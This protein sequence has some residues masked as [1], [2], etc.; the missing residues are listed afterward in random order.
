MLEKKYLGKHLYELRKSN[1]LTQ[2]ELGDIL[3]LTKQ[4]IGKIEKGER[5]A[6]IEVINAIADYF[7]VSVDYL[8][9]K[10]LFGQSDQIEKF[11]PEI[12]QV[13]KEWFGNY[14]YEDFYEWFAQVDKISQIKILQT[15]Y[16]SIEF[17]IINNEN[18][19]TFYPLLPKAQP[20]EQPR[21]RIKSPTE[22]P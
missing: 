3:G 16:A 7:K 10:G 18:T 13:T 1:K 21:I 8:L 11:M 17:E 4:M 12:M 22:E 14:F 9:G 2:Q 6:S 15:M 5:A 19:I 20:D